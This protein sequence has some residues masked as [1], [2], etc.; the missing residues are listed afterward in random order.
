VRDASAR[1]WSGAPPSGQRYLCGQISRVV[2][3]VIIGTILVATLRMP[4]IGILLMQVDMLLAM[5]VTHP[6]LIAVTFVLAIGQVA[7]WARSIWR[8]SC[9]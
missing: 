3:V 2:V 6:L 4:L 1:W 5:L 9:S 7:S 8:C